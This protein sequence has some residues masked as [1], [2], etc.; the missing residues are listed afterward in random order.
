MEAM[1]TSAYVV[2]YSPT[3]HEEA[4]EELRRAVEAAGFAVLSEDAFEGVGYAGARWGVAPREDAAFSGSAEHALQA[5][6][7]ASAK[8]LAVSSPGLGAAVVPAA[9]MEA[10]HKLLVLDVDSTL[11]KHEVIELLAAHAGKEAEVAAVTEAAMRGELEFAPS[12]HARVATLAGLEAEPR[13][14]VRQGLIEE[15]HVWLLHAH[16]P[17][18]SPFPRSYG[19]QL[20]SHRGTA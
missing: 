1:H 18:V 16:A 15:Q 11:I 8:T 19:I 14:Q 9:L 3:S 4:A 5:A 12:L 10:P 13:V 2:H 17:P 6:V 7:A 20:D